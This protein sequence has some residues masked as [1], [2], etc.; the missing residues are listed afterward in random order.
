MEPANYG[1]ALYY[2]YLNIKNESWLKAAALY[3]NEI[4]RIVPPGFNTNDS[5]FVYQLNSEC[6]FVK[7]ISPTKEA[8]EIKNDFIKFAKEE[9][10]N[11]EKRMKIHEK[12]NPKLPLDTTF[13][14]HTLK[15]DYN[16]MEYLPSGLAFESKFEPE[17]IQFEPVTGALYMTCLANKMAENRGIPVISD[18]PIYDP[19]IKYFQLDRK[20]K[21]NTD[22]SFSLGSLIIETAI[23]KN[24]NTIKAKN[25]IK[26]RNKYDDERRSFY[27]SIS[28]IAEDIPNIMDKEYMDKCLKEHQKRIDKQVKELKNG[29]KNIGFDTAPG[30]IGVSIPTWASEVS[31]ALPEEVPLLGAAG[32]C[33]LAIYKVGQGVLKYQESKRNSPWS[34]V[35]ALESRLDT[36]SYLKNLFF[37]WKIKKNI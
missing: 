15:I 35:L 1:Y 18:N 36:K 25:I 12:I 14:I 37:N 6:D 23:P 8:K 4:S 30:V 5:E 2:P 33:T 19:F 27:Y 34:Y 11:N 13:G 21:H 28:D 7:N 32:L 10:S 3:Y 22:V 17:F 31:E 9:L 26:F 24:L 29:L 20:K 16:P